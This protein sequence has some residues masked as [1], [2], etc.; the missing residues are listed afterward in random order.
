[1]IDP[2][3]LDSRRIHAI[4]LL[5]SDPLHQRAVTGVGS[6]D[7]AQLALVPDG[8]HPSLPVPLIEGR[9]PAHELTPSVRAMIETM[10]ADNA[11]T[12][13]NALAVADFLAVWSVPSLPDWAAP[14][15]EP[16]AVARVPGWLSS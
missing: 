10:E 4:L 8:R 6:W 3:L 12:L 15:P 9:A 11:D 16:L 5:A 7:G 13:R 14:V 2:Q 1:M